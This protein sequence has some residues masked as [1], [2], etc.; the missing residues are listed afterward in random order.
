[1]PFVHYKDFAFEIHRNAST[2]ME[3]SLDKVKEVIDK[4]KRLHVDADIVR[5]FFVNVLECLEFFVKK[6]NLQTHDFL[7]ETKEFLRYCHSSEELVS[8]M[9]VSLEE[10]YLS[11][12]FNEL[13]KT[14]FM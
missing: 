5:K 10:I 14:Q 13:D 7:V 4:C 2:Q 11:Q 12:E 8:Y 1:M 3:D 9:T 6:M